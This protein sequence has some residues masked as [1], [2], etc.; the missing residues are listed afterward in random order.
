MY[1]TLLYCYLWEIFQFL[2]GAPHQKIKIYREMVNCKDGAKLLDFGCAT[3][4]CSEAFGNSNYL[5]VDIDQAYIEFAKRKFNKNKNIK[6]ICSD[7]FNLDENDFDHIVCAGTGHH[8][9]DND[10]LAIH[11]KLLNKINKKGKLNFIDIIKTDEDNFFQ[12]FIYSIDQGRHVRFKHQYDKLFL[13]LKDAKIEKREVFQ[14]NNFS[15]KAFLLH[16]QI[17]KT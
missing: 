17:V 4:I 15:S 8:L 12:R 1:F 10:L 6:F 14:M 2:L 9:N 13:K 5:G 16:M 11:Q 3:G 7:V